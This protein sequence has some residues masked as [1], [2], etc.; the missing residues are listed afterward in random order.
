[1]NVLNFLL[2]RPVRLCTRSDFSV[3]SFFL[4]FFFLYMYVLSMSEYFWIIYSFSSVS[5]R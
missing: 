2:E 4:P 5:L 1:M 3:L